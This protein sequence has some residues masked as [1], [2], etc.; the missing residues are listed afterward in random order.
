MKTVAVTALMVASA[1]CASAQFG[2]LLKKD[3]PAG[4]SDPAVVL[5]QGQTLLGYVTIASDQG[6]KA[7]EAIA[8]VFPPEKVEKVRELAAKYNEMKAKRGDGNI[9]AESF[10]LVSQVAAEMAKLDAEWQA[11]VKERSQAVRK[12]DARLAL[13]LLADAQA[14][15]KAQDTAKALQSAAQDLKT[16]PTQI[17]KANRMLAMSNTLLAVSKEVPGQTSSYKTVRGTAKR[18]ADA[19]KVQLASDPSPDKVKDSTTLTS[20]VKELDS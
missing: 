15:L 12:A 13:V 4:G 11:H 10:Q 9:D 8:G 17:S 14:A 7:V 6:V 3:K 18:I 5:T 20:S 2:R 16:D 1:L 19:E